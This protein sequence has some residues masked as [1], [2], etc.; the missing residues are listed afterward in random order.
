M[1]LFGSERTAGLHHYQLTHVDNRYLDNIDEVIPK[2]V[3]ARLMQIVEGEFRWA[4]AG[5]VRSP[6]TSSRAG[7]GGA[8]RQPRDQ[9]R[10]FTE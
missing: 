6:A 3:K 7:A 2:A 4:S 1:Q 9:P 8:L 5:S 10:N